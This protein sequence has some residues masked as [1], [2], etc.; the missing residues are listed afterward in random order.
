MRAP[1]IAS[2]IGVV[3][4]LVTGLGGGVRLAYAQAGNSITGQVRVLKKNS[5]TPHDS[6]ADAVIWLSGITSPPPSTRV[7]IDQEDKKF[8]PRVLPVV[9]GQVVHFVN[10]DTIEHNVFSTE[11]E[12][13]FDLGRYPKGEYGAVT[14]DQPGRFKVYCNIH[15]SVFLDIVVVPSSHY[16][17]T[18]ED[19]EYSSEGVPDGEYVLNV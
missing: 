17:I 11:P 6:A 7:T 2:V 12:K 18:P 16:A 15:K 8:R 13:L 3:T 4:A 5:D 19:G 14:F 9:V 10:K 1:P